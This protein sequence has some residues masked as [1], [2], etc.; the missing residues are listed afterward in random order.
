MQ[1]TAWERRH[2]FEENTEKVLMKVG[3]VHAGSGY[4]QMAGTC[5][6]GDE[7]LGF[8]NFGISLDQRSHYPFR[9]YCVVLLLFACVCV[10]E[11]GSRH[12]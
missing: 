11:V 8:I 3:F 1:G 2:G 5:E 6:D 7:L 12:C 9:S 4:S 10:L